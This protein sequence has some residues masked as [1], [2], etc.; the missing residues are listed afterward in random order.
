MGFSSLDH[1]GCWWVCLGLPG[2]RETS[3]WPA[4]QQA[5]YQNPQAGWFQLELAAIPCTLVLAK[6]RFQYEF[7]CFLFAYMGIGYVIWKLGTATN[8][9][10][11][12][13]LSKKLMM[14]W[15][16]FQ[17]E[18][19][20]SFKHPSKSTRTPCFVHLTSTSQVI[21]IR[22]L[23]TPHRDGICPHHTLQ[24]EPK[25]LCSQVL[26]QSWSIPKQES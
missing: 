8:P 24:G 17:L 11:M 1:I 21:T 26:L 10:K 13:K 23:P 25:W 3:T 15:G 5:H 20:P 9:S 4:N 16:F 18:T 22:T 14:F 2:F 12:F 19:H 7:A 6:K